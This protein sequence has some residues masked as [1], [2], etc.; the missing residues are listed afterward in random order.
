MD[1]ENSQ[2]NR[3]KNKSGGLKQWM[4][5]SIKKLAI[6]DSEQLPPPDAPNQS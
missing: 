4:K 5:P 1:N 3:I 6:R 2:L